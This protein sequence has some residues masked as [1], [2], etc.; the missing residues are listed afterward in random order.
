MKN[1]FQRHWFTIVRHSGHEKQVEAQTVY[2]GT[3]GETAALLRVDPVT[4][5]ILTA[6]WETYAPEVKS[7]PV[8]GLIGV[9]AY[10]DCAPMLKDALA[11]LGDFPRSLF[12]ETVRGIIQAETFLLEERGFS[13]PFEYGKYW[14]K[15]YAGSCR[16]YSNLDR[17]TR[18]WDEYAC[19]SRSTNLFNRFK[20]QCLYSGA[21][22]GFRVTGALSDSFHELGVELCIDENLVITGAK[23]DILRAPDDVCR[24]ATGYMQNL[25]GKRVQD[26]SKK[27]VAGLLG[28]GQGCVHLIDLVHDAVESVKIC[29]ARGFDKKITF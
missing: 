27:Q 20:S 4:F 24:E 14:E 6:T 9:E 18:K 8:R 21:G 5:K 7:V 19:S 26:L 25:P 3:D 17:I 2:R 16:Y 22:A 15:F 1:F 13:T 11:G 28:A 12:A 29:T 10:F 23:G